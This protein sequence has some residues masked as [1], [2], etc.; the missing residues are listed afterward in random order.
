MDSQLSEE[1][2]APGIPNL[3]IH[4]R[5]GGTTS[6]THQFIQMIE[7]KPRSLLYRLGLDNLPA[8]CAVDVQ[9]A[10]EC[11]LRFLF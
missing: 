9:M 10:I 6:W 5:S 1:F 7:G 8:A 4:R 3:H 2:P 11:V